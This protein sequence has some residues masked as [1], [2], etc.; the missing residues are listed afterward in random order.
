MCTT[1][2]MARVCKY[3]YHSNVIY[4]FNTRFECLQYPSVAICRYFVCASFNTATIST[5]TNLTLA[6]E[7]HYVVSNSDIKAQSGF[8]QIYSGCK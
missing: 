4:Q 8:P 5:S 1:I 7:T 6:I 2:A 3:V